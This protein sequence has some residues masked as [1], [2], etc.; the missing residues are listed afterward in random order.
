[1]KPNATTCWIVAGALVL[2]VTGTLLFK[3][4]RSGTG[5][6]VIAAVEDRKITAKTLDEYLR[7]LPENYQSV[8]KNNKEALLDQ[9]IL[10]EVL[11]QE[12]ERRGYTDKGSGDASPEE[13][14]RAIQSLFMAVTEDVRITEDE[15][16][17]F[18]DEH[19]VEVQGAS[20]DEL[21][22][23]I[24]NYLSEQRKN[25]IVDEFITDQKEKAKISID[26]KWLA[27]Q[28]ASKPENPLNKALQNGMPTV[29]DLGSSSCVP[30]KMMKPIF[31]ELEKEYKDRANIILLEINDYRDIAMQYQVRVIPTQIFFDKN[32]QQVWR[33][34]GFLAKEAIIKK[35]KELGVE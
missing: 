19:P 35:L 25:E 34:E 4:F 28:A 33:H 15:M 5:P 7:S 12:A 21:K 30:C 6:S 27:K 32:G 3:A 9:L 18:Y 26:P 13:K 1:M 23:S 17:R 2:A 14:S 22:V 24:K 20:Y 11:Y 29:L 8:F 10:E 31:D 16:R